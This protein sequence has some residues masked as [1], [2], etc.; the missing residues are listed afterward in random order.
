MG[1]WKPAMS[2]RGRPLLALVAERALAHCSRVLLVTGYRAADVPGLLPENPRIRLVHN[3]GFDRGMFSSI[4]TALPEVTAETF[5]VF[6]AD[7]PAV[8]DDIVVRLAAPEISTWIRP[9]YNGKPGHPVR[10]HSRLVPELLELDPVAGEMRQVLHRYD[11]TLLETD[12]AG[13]YVDLDRPEDR[14]RLG[15]A[16]RESTGPRGQ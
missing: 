7:M 15:G 2:W 12:E 10:I 1:L 13:V 4:Q 14:A 6:L 16:G 11:G 3:A 8:P 5:F 9:A